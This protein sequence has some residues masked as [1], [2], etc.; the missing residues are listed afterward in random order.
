MRE[1][2]SRAVRDHE[3]FG[4]QC[5]WK[6]HPYAKEPFYVSTNTSDKEKL[7]WITQETGPDGDLLEFAY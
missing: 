6:Q 7:A 5:H 4:S 2:L 1:W 3:E